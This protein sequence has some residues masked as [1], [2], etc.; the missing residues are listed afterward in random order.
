MKKIL[1]HEFSQSIGP[2][3]DKEFLFDILEDMN[4][5]VGYSYYCFNEDQLNDYILSKSQRFI[6]DHYC[7]IIFFPDEENFS[8]YQYSCSWIKL[9]YDSL[10]ESCKKYY[11]LRAFV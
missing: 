4:V 1:F 6:R 10:F 2:D 9:S 3:F 7:I 5:T 11:N 8:R